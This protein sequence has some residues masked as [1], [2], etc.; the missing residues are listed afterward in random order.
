VGSPDRLTAPPQRTV[1]QIR[2]VTYAVRRS[3]TRRLMPWYELP[4]S[5]DV[6]FAE[7][8]RRRRRHRLMTRQFR[9][10]SA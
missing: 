10:V 4:G 2:F 6:T 7:M 5:G 9:W 3:C 1:Q 8:V